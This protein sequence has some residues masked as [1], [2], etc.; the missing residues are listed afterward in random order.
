M[1]K[2]TPHLEIL[3]TAQ[4]AVWPRLAEIPECFVL[5]GGTAL[6]LRLGHRESVDYDFFSGHAFRPDELV[7]SVPLLREAVPLQSGPNTF[8]CILTIGDD[9]VRLAFFGD[10]TLGQLEYPDRLDAPQLAIARMADLAATK[11]KVIQD[12]AE[13]KDYVDIAALLKAGTTLAQAVGHALGVYGPV[14]NPMI[15]LRALT[16]FSEGDLE[17]LA[18]E[19]KSLLADEAGKIDLEDITASICVQ[20][21]ISGA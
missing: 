21:R 15:S 13:A 20:A 12:R 10:L 7:R 6:G 19:V 8:E 18:T 11:L 14:F 16:Y 3:P 9:P 4:R 2:F 1:Q 5:Y 17:S